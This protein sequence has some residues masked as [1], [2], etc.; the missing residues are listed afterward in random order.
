MIRR[1]RKVQ[2][3]APPLPLSYRSAP[4]GEEG[5]LR[6]RASVIYHLVM[7]ALLLLLLVGLFLMVVSMAFRRADM[8]RSEVSGFVFVTLMIVLMAFY[9]WGQARQQFARL[10]QRKIARA[11]PRD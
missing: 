7:Y 8:E 9:F 1:R 5:P 6:V 4:P 3:P 11:R 10:N 2:E